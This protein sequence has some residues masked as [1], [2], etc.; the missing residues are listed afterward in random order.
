[1][2]QFH[3][4]TSTTDSLGAA[5]N[6][7]EYDYRPNFREFGRETSTVWNYK[8][9]G[10]YVMPW[11]IGTS[12]SYKLQSGRNWGRSAAVALPV[13]GSETIRMESVTANRAPNVS[14]LDVRLDKALKFGRMGTLTAMVDVFNLFNDGTV[15]TFRTSTG[16]T[17]GEVTS[18]LDPR[19]VRFGV[20]Y[21]F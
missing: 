2:N 17:F 5:G 16:A 6:S 11:G 15:T 12:A 7:K 9:L 20:R 8:V 14:I 19:I 3:N 13:A 18:L 1:M 21:D 4:Q 10:R